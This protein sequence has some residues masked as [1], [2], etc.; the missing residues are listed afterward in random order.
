MRTSRRTAART[1]FVYEPMETKQIVDGK[2]CIEVKRTI[3]AWFIYIN[4]RRY[5]SI[6][7]VIKEMPCQVGL[8]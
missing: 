6:I 7:G 5:L 2:I 4:C 8:T 3:R 1:D